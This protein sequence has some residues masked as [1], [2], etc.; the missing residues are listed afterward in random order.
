VISS[1]FTL[2]HPTTSRLCKSFHEVTTD[3][4]PLVVNSE[5]PSKESNFILLKKKE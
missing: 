5:Q 1:S 4:T 3:S 2:L